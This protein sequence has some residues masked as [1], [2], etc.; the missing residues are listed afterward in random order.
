MMQAFETLNVY[1]IYQLRGEININGPNDIRKERYY[2]N[3]E[4]ITYPYL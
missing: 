2:D 4:V 1:I 3:T